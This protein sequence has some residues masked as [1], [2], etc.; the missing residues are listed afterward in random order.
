[1]AG[2]GGFWD[3]V[4]KPS[5]RRAMERYARHEPKP[6]PLTR[7]E[8]AS[9]VTTLLA[10]DPGPDF[11]ARLA[12]TGPAVVPAL[13]DVLRDPGCWATKPY[14]DDFSARSPLRLAAEHFMEHPAAEAVPALAGVIGHDDKAVRKSAARAIAAVG[15]GDC[16]DPLT[17]A[18]ADA[19]EY[20]RS[21][22][23]QGAARAC[24]DGRAT[25]GF[26]A[27]AFDRVLS[28]FDADFYPA[29]EVPETL[30]E[31]DRSRAEAILLAPAHLSA[32]NRFLKCNLRAMD[33]AGVALPFE[34]LKDLLADLRPRSHDYPASY[35]CR[36]AL[37]ALGR[38]GSPEAEPILRDALTWGGEEVKDGAASGLLALHGVGRPFDAMNP[39][40]REGGFDA[41]T[42][43]QK[44]YLTLID[45]D[46]QVRNGGFHQYFV[47]SYG[48][49]A[50]FAP[51]AA[52]RVPAPG[53][54]AVIRRAVALFGPDGPP[55]DRDDRH[56]RLAAFTAE[57]DA[58]LKALDTAYYGVPDK[59]DTL[60][61]LYAVEHASHFRA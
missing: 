37:T 49:N 61:T 34:R 43:P 32:G 9:L 2:E 26:R 23:L 51:R 17:V 24:K 44:V 6:R 20:V 18:L 41:L 55:R 11:A 5:I 19:D 30:L 13:L 8:L 3:F 22:A 4:K 48:G 53:H 50:W 25:P 33:E 21:Y 1:M 35:S 56:V 12:A 58:E 60:L 45:L 40:W 14:T 54:A 29:D 31:L 28:L 46:G 59:L 36:Y 27:A 42:E 52:E 16:I 57:Q 7:R 15:T 39:R 47:N 10:R 38:T